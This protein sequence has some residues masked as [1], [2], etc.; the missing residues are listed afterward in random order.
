MCSKR[1][2]PPLRHYHLPARD[3]PVR[4]VEVRTDSYTV[5]APGPYAGTDPWAIRV[6]V[7]DGLPD[8]GSVPCCITG[9]VEL[10]RTTA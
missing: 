8:G 1:F 4:L 7:L 3:I 10:P 2:L 6:L 9:L 5:D